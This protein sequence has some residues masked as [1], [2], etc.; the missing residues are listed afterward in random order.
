MTDKDRKRGQPP[1]MPVYR[2]PDA[3]LTDLIHDDRALARP[4][5][6]TIN[7]NETGLETDDTGSWE[8]E[9][10]TDVVCRDG[11]K[12]GE[13][14]DVM[15]GYMVV[16]QGFFHP[17]DIYVP[18]GLIGRHD[19]D[20]TLR[21]SLTRDEFERADWSHEPDTEPSEKESTGEDS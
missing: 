1:Q 6:G 9:Q 3:G 2:N 18:L 17:R 4:V 20:D 8:I 15:P 12:I 21:L 11:G 16:E 19:D 13:V 14:V 7:V 10:G 5:A